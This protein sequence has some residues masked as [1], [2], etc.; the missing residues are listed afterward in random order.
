MNWFDGVESLQ[1]IR[2]AAI[3]E[4]LDLLAGGSYMRYL[5]EC[6]I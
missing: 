6:S 1:L 3:S 2:F 5:I 4:I